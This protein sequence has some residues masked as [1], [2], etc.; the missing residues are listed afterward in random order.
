MKDSF[1]FYTEYREAIEDMTDEEAGMLLKALISYAEGE[2]IKIKDKAVRM[3]FL[4]IKPRLDRDRAKWQE[5]VEKRREA[6]QKGGEANAS[7]R[8]QTQAKEASAS[9]SKQNVA[10]QAVSVTVTDSDSE[11]INNPACARA[12]ESQTQMFDRLITGRALSKSTSDKLREWIEYKTGRNERYKEKGMTALITL[13]VNK[14]AEYGQNA[15]IDLIDQA[16][17]S[18]YKGIT[19]DRLKK[20][21]PAA[22]FNNEVSRG[23]VTPDLERELLGVRA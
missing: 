5:T 18:G 12:R 17:A 13:A 23:K 14:C 22:K 11:Y 9:K 21:R 16:M 4:T 7:K 10:N 1:I 15:V 20:Q 3:V 2:E 8:K 19:W 6:G